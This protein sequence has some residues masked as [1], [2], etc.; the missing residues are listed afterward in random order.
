MDVPAAS[1]GASGS[2]GAAPA[3]IC[4]AQ[5]D[6]SAVLKMDGAFNIDPPTN[7]IGSDGIQGVSGV[8]GVPGAVC[9]NSETNQYHGVPFKEWHWQLMGP[10]ITM[11]TNYKV[12]FHGTGIL[13]CKEYPNAA[14]V[15]SPN[16]GR[17]G[18]YDLWCPEG[19][20]PAL[21]VPGNHWNTVMLSVTPES[22]TTAPNIGPMKGPMPTAGNWW[23]LNECPLGVAESHQTWKVDFEKSITVPGGS[24]VNFVEFDTNCKEIVNCG[25]S[26]DATM[27]C[28]THYSITPPGAPVP[29]PPASITQQP[30]AAGGGAYGQWIFFDVKTIAPM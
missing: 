3:A 8:N 17:D 1:G 13:E 21:T 27:N 16:Q 11:G 12:T 28:P 10:G 6:C 2:G 20:D 9:A 24:W 19:K 23:Q 5:G 18:T 30:A 7:Q 29:A 4:T 25:N 14:C 26:P 22:S 15:R